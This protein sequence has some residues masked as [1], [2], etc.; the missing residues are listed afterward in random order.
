MGAQRLL[1][2]AAF[3]A[4]NASATSYLNAPYI[5]VTGIPCT[6]ITELTLNKKTLK[7]NI[8]KGARNCFTDEGTTTIVNEAFQSEVDSESVDVPFILKG[9]SAY[10]GTFKAG[11]SPCDQKVHLSASPTTT[12]FTTTKIPITKSASLVVV[13]QDAA[14]T[15]GPV[16]IVRAQIQNIE[17]VGGGNTTAV[18]VAVIEGLLLLAIFAYIIY[19]F[20]FRNRP[21]NLASSRFNNST[22]SYPEPVRQPNPPLPMNNFT[23]SQPPPPELPQRGWSRQPLQTATT[24]AVDPLNAWEMEEHG[25]HQNNGN[26][27]HLSPSSALPSIPRVVRRRSSCRIPL[28]ATISMTTK[29]TFERRDP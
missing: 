9:K 2:V 5:K 25:P 17:V 7:I 8:T 1:L 15:K 13:S 29:T 12:T 4:A 22:M 10:E 6:D 28:T 20:C 11:S 14:E 3:L 23:Q 26:A 19:I 24:P 21:S 27:Q 16:F 18:V